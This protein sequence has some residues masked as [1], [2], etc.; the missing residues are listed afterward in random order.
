MTYREL[1]P[2]PALASHVACFWWRT[3]VPGRVLPDGCVDLVWTGADLI[4]AGPA[5]QAVIPQ[6]PPEETKVGVQ[7]G[8]LSK[9]LAIS[10]RQLRRRFE[11]TVGY[12]PR[13]L[14]RVLRL[15]RF[16][17]VARGSDDLARIAADAG[18]ADQPHLTRDCARLAGL[19]AAALLATG[20]GPAGERLNSA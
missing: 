1:A 4:V 6:V 3:G 8:P 20:A 17:S 16:L 10:E 11:R 13:M 14:A 9:R 5:T 19:P 18:Y 2:P 12:S 7:I 15:Q